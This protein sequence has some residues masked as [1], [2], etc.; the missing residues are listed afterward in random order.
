MPLI[1]DQTPSATPRCA[2]G[3]ASASSVSV[4]GVA[5]AA[6]TPWIARAAI[7]RPMRRRERGGGG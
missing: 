3:N 7:S 5:I 1:A 2:G 4:S 6:P